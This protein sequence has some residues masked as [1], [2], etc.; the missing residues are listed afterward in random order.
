MSIILDLRKI[1]DSTLREVRL[2][3]EESGEALPQDVVMALINLAKPKSEDDP[4]RYQVVKRGEGFLLFP[5][6]G[7]GR[8]LQYP[9]N[10]SSFVEAAE[11]ATKAFQNLTTIF[12]EYGNST[13]TI[14]GSAFNLT[15]DF[16]LLTNFDGVE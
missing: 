14:S 12:Q 1:E 15:N 4:R 10:L 3:D 5:M 7:K 13:A 8:V 16:I 6:N 11:R 9:N 2:K